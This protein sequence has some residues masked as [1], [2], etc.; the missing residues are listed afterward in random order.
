MFKSWDK[1]QKQYTELDNMINE[2]YD[3]NMAHIKQWNSQRAPLMS[4]ET[5]LRKQLAES[6]ARERVEL[7]KRIDEIVDL[8][9]PIDKK[10]DELEHDIQTLTRDIETYMKQNLTER[11]QKR[12]RKYGWEI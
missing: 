1:I 6:T 7:E 5:K 4:E 3:K 11:E 9:K 12:A 10:L 8:L 2:R